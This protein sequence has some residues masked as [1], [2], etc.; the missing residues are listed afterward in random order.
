MFMVYA[1][2]VHMHVC[3]CIWILMI[4][5]S[6]FPFQFIKSTEAQTTSETA[7]TSANSD[8]WLALSAATFAT[9]SLTGKM[10]G[11]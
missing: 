6:Y 3:A 8:A 5:Q 10:F 4:H 7:S 1:L 11:N 2:T 9:S